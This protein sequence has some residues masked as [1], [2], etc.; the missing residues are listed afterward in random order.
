MTGHITHSKNPRTHEELTPGQP[1]S[2]PAGIT[3]SQCTVAT[4][5]ELLALADEFLRTASPAAHTELRAYLD[6]QAPPAAPAWFIDM[7]GLNAT[8]LARHLPTRAPTPRQT[9][10][11]DPGAEIHDDEWGQNT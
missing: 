8:H 11:R 2:G 9:W 6:T 5:R 7:L 1:P 10:A 3:L 4:A